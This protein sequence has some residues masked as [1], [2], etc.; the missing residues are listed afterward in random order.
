[1]PLSYQWFTRSTK[2]TTSPLTISHRISLAH[3]SSSVQDVGIEAHRPS[4]ALLTS[5]KS[6]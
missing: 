3:L 1:M 6:A 4:G 5:S 2:M